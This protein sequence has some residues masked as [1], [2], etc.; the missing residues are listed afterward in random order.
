MALILLVVGFLM[1][2]HAISTANFLSRKAPLT[3]ALEVVFMFGFSVGSVIS[4][5][6]HDPVGGMTFLVVAL[7]NKVLLI[8]DLLIRGYPMRLS[9]ITC[10]FDHQDPMFMA[11]RRRSTD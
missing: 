6:D 3:I 5:F 11:P 1:A 2:A 4:S 10:D 8:V 9:L 7:G